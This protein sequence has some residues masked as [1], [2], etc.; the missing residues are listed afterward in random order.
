MRIDRLESD[1]H[2]SEVRFSQQLG[3]LRLDSLAAEFA[4]VGPLMIR[5][6]LCQQ[7]QKAVEV[8]SLVERRVEQNDFLDAA[9]GRVAKIGDDLLFGNEIESV[10]TLRVVTELAFEDATAN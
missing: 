2:L 4:E 5:I 10:V 9:F 7:L 8:F 1:L 6:A 3:G